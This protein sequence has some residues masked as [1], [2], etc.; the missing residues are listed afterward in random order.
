MVR[1]HLLQQW[2]ALRDPA[3]EEGLIEVP[4]MRRFGGIE[5][6]SAGSQMKQ[7]P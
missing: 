5:L 7:Q 3:M 4:T 2:Y 6:I 1:I